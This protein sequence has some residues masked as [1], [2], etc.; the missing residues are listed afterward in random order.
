MFRFYSFS[1]DTPASTWTINHNL[2]SAN[3]TI[4]T[5]VN[6]GGNLEKV[7]PYDVVATN[8]NTLTVTFTSAQTG[9]ATVAGA[10]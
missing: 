10:G 2:N 3:I 6:F 5:M 9:K 1:Q 7:I 4:D 8:T